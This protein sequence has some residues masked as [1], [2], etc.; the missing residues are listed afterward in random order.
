MPTAED[1]RN[2]IKPVVDPELMLS[3]VDLGLIYDVSVDEEQKK[4]TITMTLTSP[5]CPVG[6]QIIAGVKSA[7]ES[8]EGIEQAHI[9]LVWNPPWDP[10]QMATDDVK[11]ILGIW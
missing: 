7:A 11:D 3:V 4:A 9:E 8:V 6:P 1:I 10:A 5:M 2:A